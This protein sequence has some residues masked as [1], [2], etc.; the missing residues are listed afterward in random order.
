MNDITNPI[1]S[2][3]EKAFLSV[4][5]RYDF[6]KRSA[7]I[8]QLNAMKAGD[9]TRDVTPHYWIMEFR[10]HGINPGHGAM[11]PYIM[12]E[13]EHEDGTVPTVFTLYER[14]GMVFELEVYNEDSSVMD[15]DSL[16]KGHIRVLSGLN[17]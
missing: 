17:Q 15:L 3:R 7:V 16:T 8:D 9:V 12:M 14:N 13:V 6:P 10:P 2:Q 11:R 1:F 4:F 5:L